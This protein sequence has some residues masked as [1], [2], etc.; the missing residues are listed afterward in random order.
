MILL[1]DKLGLANIRK[2]KTTSQFVSKIFNKYLKFYA[3]ILVNPW[4][5]EVIQALHKPMITKEELF[6]IQTLLSGKKLNVKHGR[7]N[8][9]FPLRG[10]MLC[11]YCGRLLT[12]SCS[13][14]NGGKY[15]YY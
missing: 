7:K 14:G 5:N 6:K 13:H 1:L 8:P 12:A 11:S 2:K 3:G 4:T 10:T 9:N 15:Y